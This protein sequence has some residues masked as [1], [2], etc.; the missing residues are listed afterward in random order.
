MDQPVMTHHPAD[1]ASRLPLTSA[2]PGRPPEASLDLWLL[3]DIPRTKNPSPDQAILSPQERHRAARFVRAQ[4]R[5]LYTF[6]HGALRRLLGERLGLPPQ[7]VA[8]T[9]ESCPC[10]GAPHGRPALADPPFPLH[11]SLSH[12]DEYVMIGIAATPV[13]VDVEAVPAAGV[14]HDLTIKLHP[15]EQAELAALGAGQRTA[16]MARIWTR[17]EAYLKG[18]GTGLGRGLAADYVGPTGLASPPPDWTIADLPVDTA[19]AAAWAVLGPSPTP[20]V[21]FRVD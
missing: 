9:R 11:F 16:A 6:A 7:D 5:H 21:Y 17:K 10:C 19:H 20:R 18:I 2:L 15:A 3:G 14:V 8:F 4:D 1:P 13:G 12:C